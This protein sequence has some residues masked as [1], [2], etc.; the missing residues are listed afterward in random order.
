MDSF[1]LLQII[2][3]IPELRFTHKG[4]YPSDRGSQLTKYS[5]A[6]INS[7]PSNDRGEHWIMIARLNKTYYFAA[8]LVKKKQP[9]TF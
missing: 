4:S 3:R 1:S 9:I 8:S 2:E 7:A 5:F 6:V